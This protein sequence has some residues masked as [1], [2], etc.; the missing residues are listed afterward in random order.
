MRHIGFFLKHSSIKTKFINF[1]RKKSL[2]I[3]E[4]FRIKDN[5]IYYKD[6]CLVFKNCSRKNKKS[7][8]FRGKRHFLRTFQGCTNHEKWSEFKLNSTTTINITRIGLKMS[9]ELEFTLLKILQKTPI[10][11]TNIKRPTFLINLL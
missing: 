7:S 5:F 10:I 9:Q 4:I 11:A 6:F 2:K 8:T 1:F 3:I